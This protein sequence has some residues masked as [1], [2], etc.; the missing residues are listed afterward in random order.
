M[1]LMGRPV[2]FRQERPGR[3][4]KLFTLVKF[5]TMRAGPGHDADRLTRFGRVLRSTSLDELPELWNIIRGD[6][7]LVGPRPLLP[8]Y[9]PLY[10]G[11]QA[12]RHEVRPGLTGLAQV[13]G[14]NQVGWDYRLELDVQYVEHLSLQADLAILFRTIAPVVK[15]EGVSA[16][17]HATVERFPG[18]NRIGQPARPMQAPTRQ[19]P[20]TPFDVPVIKTQARQ[21]ALP[22]PYSSAAIRPIPDASF[23]Q[24]TDHPQ[25]EIQDG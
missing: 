7:S 23:R 21:L 10:S 19:Y 24:V 14:R 16:K 8:E 17:D 3:N 9:L 13:N 22:N 11:R 12:R 1:A 6:M 4:G 15:R 2:L 5:R 18:S 25:G 20:G